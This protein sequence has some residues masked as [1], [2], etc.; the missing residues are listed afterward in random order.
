MSPLGPSALP[1]FCLMQH[2]A[3]LSSTDAD[4]SVPGEEIWD[5]C[6]QLQE[7]VDHGSGLLTLS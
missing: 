7:K 6:V 5:L 2:R 4:M 3:H 1:Y